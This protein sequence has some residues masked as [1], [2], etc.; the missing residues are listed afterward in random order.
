MT[1]DFEFSPENTP[2]AEPSTSHQPDSAVTIKLPLE[3][4]N[5][6]AQRMQQSGQTQ[7]QIILEELQGAFTRSPEPSVEESPHFSA[8]LE[9]LKQ[10]LA[11]LESLFPKVAVLEGKLTAF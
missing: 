9:Q 1:N 8:E 3:L 6:I 5:A 11:E 4:M 10:R 7:A 2:V